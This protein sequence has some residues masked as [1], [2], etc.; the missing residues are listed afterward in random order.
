MLPG[1]RDVW[2]PP[3]PTATE[4]PSLCPTAQQG[5]EHPCPYTPNKTPFFCSAS[6]SAP[7]P[8]SLSIPEARGDIFFPHLWCLVR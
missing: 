2:P 5:W 6:L 8:A 3:A 7:S 1:P 4:A